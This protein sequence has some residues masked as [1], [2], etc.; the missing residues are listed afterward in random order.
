MRKKVGKSSLRYVTISLVVF[1]SRS[2]HC[3]KISEEDVVL[4]SFFFVWKVP[5]LLDIMGFVL[6]LCNESS[7]LTEFGKFAVRF[8]T[9][10]FD[11]AQNRQSRRLVVVQDRLVAALSTVV[12]RAQMD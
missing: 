3:Y 9:G 11:S 10:S 4:G 1:V 8:F 12:C 5:T 6:F 2:P 7:I